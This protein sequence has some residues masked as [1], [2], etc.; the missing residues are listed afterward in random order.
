MKIATTPMCQ[1][2]LNLAG[3]LEFK[4][5]NNG[6]YD[7]ADI[8]IVLSETKIPENSSTKYIK[9]KL[10]TFNQIKESIQL[11]SDILETKPL[12]ENISY[13]S[14]NHNQKN[15]KIRIKVH[16]NFLKEIAEDMGFQIVE[17]NYDYL[18]YPDYLKK[19]LKKEL[20]EAGERAIELPTHAN[21][22]LNPI[23]RAEIR[24]KI[25]EKGICMR[26]FG[27]SD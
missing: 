23:K 2:I 15:K 13:I 3:V 20:T 17:K 8:A 27:F 11:I 16:S 6:V 21:V 10:N 18:I 1:E 5:V 24:Y 12:N 9:L 26:L 22:P 25:L 14:I 7:D 4:I 19:K